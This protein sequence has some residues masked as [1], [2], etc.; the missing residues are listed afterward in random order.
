LPRA[1]PMWRDNRKWS[2]SLS[3]AGS[4]VDVWIQHTGV[5]QKMVSVHDIKSACRQLCIQQ[6]QNEPECMG[7]ATVCG[8]GTQQLTS[9]L[10]PYW[11]SGQTVFFGLLRREWFV[12][13]YGKCFVGL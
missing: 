9:G 5:L 7:N 1:L 10:S 8:S 3:V 6:Y 11:F 2:L 4:K 13:A 12:F